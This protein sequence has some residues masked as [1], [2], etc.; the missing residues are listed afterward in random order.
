MGARFNYRRNPA[1]ETQVSAVRTTVWPL[2]HFERRV[3]AL[4][5][6]KP[7]CSADKLSVS[8][9]LIACLGGI[10]TEF[11]LE[12]AL[13]ELRPGLRKAEPRQNRER[14]V[15]VG[16]G[17]EG[18]RPGK[19]N[20][21]EQEVIGC[22]THTQEEKRRKKNNNRAHTKSRAR[23]SLKHKSMVNLERG[24]S[25][26]PDNV[27]QSVFVNVCHLTGLK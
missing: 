17:G 1:A 25:H 5:T 26:T 21:L 19:H 10:L 24:V 9:C 11:Q 12:F 13:I 16:G 2:C 3:A 27:S 15:R 6:A 18:E 4:P 22:E 23:T 20:K 8:V 14:G 7:R